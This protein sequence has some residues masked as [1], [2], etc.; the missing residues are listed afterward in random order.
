[1]FCGGVACLLGGVT[2]DAMVRVLGRRWGRTAQGVLSYTCGGAFF[3]IALFVE[4][5]VFSVLFLCL[6]SFSKDMAMGVSWATCCDIGHRYSGSVAGFMNMVGNFGSV[7]SA[8]F[9]AWLAGRLNSDATAWGAAQVVSGGFH[10]FGSAVTAPA[11]AQ[12]GTDQ[13]GRGWNVALT[14]SA[15]ALFSAAIGWLFI[16][17]RHVI[18]YAPDDHRRLAESGAL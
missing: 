10:S 7:V 17:P 11:V 4:H 15:V 9:V 5:P 1:M 16:D 14:V 2:T 6:A 18:V 8:P 12:W 3:L 13:I